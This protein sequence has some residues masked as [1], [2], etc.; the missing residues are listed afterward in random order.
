MNDTHVLAASDA[1]AEST[2]DK[3]KTPTPLIVAIGASAGGLE[4]IEQFLEHV[5]ALSGMAYVVIQHMDPSHQ[6][7]MMVELLSRVTPMSVLIAE[8]DMQVQAD[9][10]YVIP[11][12]K[13]MSILHG[14]I[15][16]LEQVPI[17]GVRMPVDYFFRA[18][19][20]DQHENAIGVV[21]SGMGTDGTLGLRAIKERGGLALVQEPDTARFDSMPRTAITTVVVDIVAP[22]D[23]LPKQLIN[24]LQTT[25]RIPKGDKMLEVKSQSALEKIVVLLREQTG[26]DMSMYKKSSMYRRIERRMG[27][28][29]I[30]NI[31]NYVRYLRENTQE[32]ELLF[33]ELLIGVTSFFRDRHVWDVLRQEVFPDLLSRHPPGKHFRAW[34]PACSTGEEAFS[35]A[36]AFREAVE[37]FAPDGNY[38]LQIFAT[39]LDEDA[40]ERARMGFYPANIAADVPPERLKRFFT[41]EGKG[42]RVNKQ[43]R[44]KVIFAPQN[45]IM[46][47]PFTKLDLISCRNLMIYLGHE[48]QQKLFPLFHYVLNPNGLLLVGTAETVNA[49]GLFSPANNKARLYQKIISPLD[50]QVVPRYFPVVHVAADARKTA[51][52][53]GNLQVLADQFLLQNFAPPAVLINNDGD[54]LYVSGRTG[55]FLEPA[56]GKANWN[57][58][59]MAKEELR[60]ELTM[61]VK[62]ALRQTDII[63]SMAIKL[64]VEGAQASVSILAQ[65][66]EKPT[67]LQGTIIVVFAQGENMGESIQPDWQNPNQRSLLEELRHAQEELLSTREEMQTSQEEFKATY[68]ELHTINEELQTANEELST[69]REEMQSVNE[70]LHTVNL[71]LQA[72]MDALSSA[73]N[74][75]VNLISGTDI[76]AVFLD[77]S[78]QVRRFT[79]ASTQLFKLIPSD[80]GRPLTDVVTAL[81]YPDL[82]QDAM[83]V[84]RSLVN[85][86]KLIE[87]DGNRH[88][89]ARIL[90]YRTLENIVDGVLITFI[91]VSPETQKKFH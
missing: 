84:L 88:Y 83:T 76:I 10:V 82:A 9:C 12:S 45:L 58:Y 63:K 41:P 11:P 37:E 81:Q 46:D 77:N 20:D 6:K 85:I 52:A 72:K 13:D 47:P 38:S 23:E 18:L 36:I 75:L 71:E 19:A 53:E 22:P 60:H 1:Q 43:I 51:A 21:L 66:I 8:T 49:P 70:E 68:E 25:T 15:Q 69:S 16:L 24:Y 39:D 57:I 35:L 59:A 64:L 90:P 67:A 26:H 62:R 80:I 78:L 31:A 73:N 54:I 2:T 34:V 91:D 74:D 3:K 32:L 50:K 7:S 56:A 29:Q 48:L 17:R 65:Q 33:K 14:R 44:E 55:R 87:A 42:Y 30:E 4:A 61:T 5:P 89:R 28:H 79:P 27:L 86:D 40:I